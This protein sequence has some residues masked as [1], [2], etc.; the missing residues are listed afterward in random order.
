MD[1]NFFEDA[2][3]Q[4]FYT[5]K[6]GETNEQ[7]KDLDYLDLYFIELKKYKGKLQN[8]RTTLERWIT[9]LNNANVYD[10]KNLPKELAEIKEIRKAAQRLDTMYLD[11]QERNYYESQQKFWLDQNS[12]MK[13]TIEKAVQEAVEKAKQEL[14]VEAMEEAERKKQI[15][16]AKKMILAG[17]ENNFIVQITG[18]T[19]EQIET[20]RK[21]IE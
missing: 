13:E 9:F 6:D 19:P 7:H 12:F 8:V 17:S 1:F 15:E 4:R 5:L 11:E 16:I 3:Y 2:K 20:L 14:R 10:N 18:L 21:E